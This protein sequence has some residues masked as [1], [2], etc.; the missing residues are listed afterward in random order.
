MK[1][2]LKLNY[3]ISCCM[4]SM[5][6]SIA[7]PL[8]GQNCMELVRNLTNPALKS[9]PIYFKDIIERNLPLG[10]SPPKIPNN[11]QTGCLRLFGHS[12]RLR[13]IV[14][15]VEGIV[16]GLTSYFNGD[17]P[18]KRKQTTNPDENFAQSQPKASPLIL[19][20]NFSV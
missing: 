12:S 17:Q 18:S 6:I 3:T 20:F 9:C 19:G 15:N 16:E 7:R 11:C 4:I 5:R 13:S 14:L 10:Q 1:K 2:A 8:P